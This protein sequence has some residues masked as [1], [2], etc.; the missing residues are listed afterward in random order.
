MYGIINSI[1]VSYSRCLRIWKLF[2]FEMDLCQYCKVKDLALLN[3][4]NRDR[5]INKCKKNNPRKRSLIQGK[6]NFQPK[7]SQ[8]VNA[9][10]KKVLILELV[11][12]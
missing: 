4:T 5:H 9:E 10:S 12:K 8:T 6:W 2:G 3:E 1:F 11:S 7:A